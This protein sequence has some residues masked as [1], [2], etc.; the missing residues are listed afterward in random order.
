MSAILSCSDSLGVNGANYSK[1]QLNDEVIRRDTMIDFKKI[2]IETTITQTDTIIKYVPVNKVYDLVY[3]NRYNL[4]LVEYYLNNNGIVMGEP[5]AD[6]SVV[7]IVS[8]LNYNTI[9][10]QISFKLRLDN[11]EK[12][13]NHDFKDRSELIN[14]ISIEFKGISILNDSPLS[15]RDLAQNYGLEVKLSLTN[16]LGETRE[17]NADNIFGELQ[18]QNRLVQNG[19]LRGMSLRGVMQIPSNDQ[20]SLKK[21]AIEFTALLFFPE[22]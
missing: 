16:R 7:E 19:Q 8:L 13:K 14:S 4:Q 6:D 15:F 3:S 5:L 2:I 1:S 22:I 11:S 10:P 21:Y 9:T 18:V 17:L 12:I 20:F